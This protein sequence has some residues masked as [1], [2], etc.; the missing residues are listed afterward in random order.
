MVNMTAGGFFA[1]GLVA[2][3]QACLGYNC[4]NFAFPLAVVTNTPSSFWNVSDNTTPLGVEYVKNL[5]LADI[6]FVNYAGGDFYLDPLTSRVWFREVDIFPIDITGKRKLWVGAK[7]RMYPG[8]HTPYPPV[9]NYLSGAS[10]I[11]SL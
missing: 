5:T 8:A 6:G 3:W 10:G 4:N 7:T 1:A 9:P 11:R 2:A